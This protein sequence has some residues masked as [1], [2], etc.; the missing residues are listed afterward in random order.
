MSRK[1]RLSKTDR[2][3]HR[4]AM[5]GFDDAQIL[6]ITGPLE[7]FSRTS[8][9]LVDQGLRH[10]PCYEIRL[11]GERRGSI[12]TSGGIRLEVNG[13]YSEAGR[14]DTLLVAGGIGADRV[15]TNEG[16]LA[17][18]RAQS[19]KVDRLG[20]ICT[21]AL[22]LATAGLLKDRP[23]TTHWAYCDR[24]GRMAPETAVNADAIYVKSGRVYTSA[25][26]TTGMDM[27]LAMVEED[28]GR[29]VALAVA[30]ELVMFLKRPGGQSQFSRHLQA[31]HTRDQR[32]GELELWVL[33]NLNRELSVDELATRVSMSAR[34]F[35]RRFAAEVGT[36]PAEYVARARVDAA[37][38]LLEETRLTLKEVAT[39]CGFSEE[40]NLR[41]AFL[42]RLRVTPTDYR[43]KWGRIYFPTG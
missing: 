28:H 33:D 19:K 13:G 11:L 30:Q 10:A 43:G 34:H 24:L 2:R 23:A 18:L 3:P 17:W 15:M 31:Q 7:V 4:V 29:A 38:R 22:I 20:S 9:W 6:D 8:R 40:Q 36:T 42:K 32:L 1:P 37:R 12:R 26:V 25:G 39:R 21:G 41:R 35:A 27:A 14:I 16:L 5:V